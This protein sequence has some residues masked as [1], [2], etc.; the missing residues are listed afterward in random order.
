MK[1]LL[2]SRM[3]EPVTQE[4]MSFGDEEEETLQ[5]QQ[6]ESESSD[7]ASIPDKSRSLRARSVQKRLQTELK[8]KGKRT[9]DSGGK[10]GRMTKYRRKAA[11]AKER[12][13]MAKVNEAF[14][15]LR[16]VMPDLALILED[17]KDTKVTTLRAAI[18]YIYG[19]QNLLEDLQAGN[20]DPQQYKQQE[21]QVCQKKPFRATKPG[22]KPRSTTKTQIKPNLK[23]SS[24]TL[25][26]KNTNTK[27]CERKPNQAKYILPLR[28]TQEEVVS[29]PA[30]IIL[31]KTRDEVVPSPANLLL[32]TNHQHPMQNL[33]VK[34]FENPPN[35]LYL[36]PIP[37]ADL[38]DST[39]L[40]PMNTLKKMA[41]MSTAEPVCEY[42]VILNSAEDLSPFEE[43][44]P[45]RDSGSSTGF[46]FRSMSAS[47]NSSLAGTDVDLMDCSESLDKH[48]EDEIP[49][50]PTDLF[51]TIDQLFKRIPNQTVE[52][53]QLSDQRHLE[54][55]DQ[56]I[57]LDDIHQIIGE[58]TSI[59]S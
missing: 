57:I 54:S 49:G 22:C 19:L 23:I 34:T 50:S 32:H 31:Q 42:Y 15:R 18:T 52:A 48:D 30:N 33:Q 8:M 27:K 24:V 12:E 1:V 37:E 16:E 55:M 35:L 17:E 51:P 13:R 47:P 59:G 21:P 20:I 3:I 9:R 36:K 40:P 29:S 58:T 6:N 7:L 41:P 10:A 4:E 45:R 28:S 25:A 46:S 26:A 2:K 43:L 53:D 44:R 39:K 14:E 56:L 38:A 11:N 5:P